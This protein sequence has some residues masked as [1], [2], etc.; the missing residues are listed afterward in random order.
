MALSAKDL[1][2]FHDAV[3]VVCSS[4][5]CALNLKAPDKN[6]RADLIKA[7]ETELMHQLRD[8]TDLATGLLLALLILIARSEKSAVHASG[9]FVSHL[10]SKVE[11]YPD[12]TAQLS[13]LLTSA[14]KLVITKMQQK[15]DENLE[16]KLEEKLMAIKAALNGFEYVEKTTIDEDLNET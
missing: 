8:C 9:K 3:S 4:A 6:C 5:V 11:K 13:D 1:E 14:Q 12:T 15:G 2:S 10:I 16:V 7:Y